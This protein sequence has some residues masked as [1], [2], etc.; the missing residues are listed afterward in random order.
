MVSF[1]AMQRKIVALSHTRSVPML[2]F[3]RIAASVKVGSKQPF[4]AI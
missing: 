1:V 4:A 2:T 3:K